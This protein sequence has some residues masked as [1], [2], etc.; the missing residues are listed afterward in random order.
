NSVLTSTTDKT[1]CTNQLPYLWNGQNYNAAGTY[2]KTLTSES[3][4]DSVATLNL[5]VNSVLTSTTN[6]TVCTNQLPYFWNGQNYNAA[7]TYTKTLTSESGC[8]S[9]ATLNLIVNSVLT[10]TTNKTVCTNQLPYFWNGQN[11]NA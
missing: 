8:D 7:G 2:T 10:S 5:I 3:G 9:V 11:Y 1:V 6:K 4:C